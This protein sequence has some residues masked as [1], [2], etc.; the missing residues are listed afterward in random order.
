MNY[1]PSIEGYFN[2]YEECDYND[3]DYY[4]SKKFRAG[5]YDD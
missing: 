5:D 4:D 3:D 2:D 1:V